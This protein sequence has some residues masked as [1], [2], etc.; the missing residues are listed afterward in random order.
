MRFLGTYLVL[1]IVFAFG[2]VYASAFTVGVTPN[3]RARRCVEPEESYL[4]NF[5]QE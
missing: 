3:C 2:F 5:Y 1:V 4:S